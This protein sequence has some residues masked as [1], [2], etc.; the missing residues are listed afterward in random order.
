MAV[1]YRPRHDISVLC[2]HCLPGT[3]S[4]HIEPVQPSLKNLITSL[5]DRLFP[6]N[7]VATCKD[8]IDLRIMEVRDYAQFD[9]ERDNIRTLDDLGR[10]IVQSDVDELLC[11]LLD[12]GIVDAIVPFHA[13]GTDPLP[14]P[15]QY[16]QAD[17]TH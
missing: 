16:Q 9:R 7:L 10:H 13:D 11:K 1:G 5:K 6:N 12:E 17:R 3:G 8:V 15:S 2:H 14:E 4:A